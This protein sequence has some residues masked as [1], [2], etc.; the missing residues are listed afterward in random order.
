MT[1]Q[2]ELVLSERAISHLHVFAFISRQEMIKVIVRQGLFE[3]SD[4][5]IVSLAKENI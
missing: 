4:Y 3:F 1:I 2:V 5:S